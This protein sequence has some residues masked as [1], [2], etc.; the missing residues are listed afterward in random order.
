MDL[1]QEH[2]DRRN[3]SC[4][5]FSYE[6][7]G[8]S[9]HDDL[10]QSISSAGFYQ[11]MVDGADTRTSQINAAEYES[12]FARFLERRGGTCCTCACPPG[13]RAR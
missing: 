4:I 12:Y 3:I 10:W 2:L 11:A 6:L 8:T 13:S 9:Y 5:P 1:T 7:G